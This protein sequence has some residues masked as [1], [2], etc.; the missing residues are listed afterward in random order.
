MSIADV[1]LY[2]LHQAN[3]KMLEAIAVN[4]AELYDVPQEILAGKIPTTIDFLGN[5]SVATIPT[6]LDLVRK[7]KLEGH[8]IREGDV[9]VMASVGAGM[10]CNAIVYRF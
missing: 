2:L 8:E 4:L 6:M 7:H 9:V 3:A 1:D 5:T 10:H